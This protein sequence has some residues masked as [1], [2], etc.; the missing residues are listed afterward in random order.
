MKLLS[1]I[2]QEVIGLFL[3]DEFLAIA[4]LAVV[5]AAAFGAWIGLPHL[6]V[7]AILLLGCVA[8]LAI[9]LARAR[10]SR[11]SQAPTQSPAT[12]R[13]LDG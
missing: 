8:V 11:E 12:P 3:D 7:A 9:S 10:P 6:V 4:I 13:S 5:I 2:A 1:A